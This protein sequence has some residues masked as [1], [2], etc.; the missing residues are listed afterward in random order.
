MVQKVLVISQEYPPKNGGAGVYG[1]N[2]I[3]LLNEQY[4]VE[5]IV[6]DY[7]LGE[8][9]FNTS[10][11]RPV[12]GIGFLQI[13]LHFYTNILLLRKKYDLIIL[14]DL[15]ASLFG[16]LLLYPHY[17]KKTISI[18]H[19]SEPEVIVDGERRLY[20][21]LH[22]RQRYLKFLE[23]IKCVW[24]VSKDLQNKMNE[25][26]G[27]GALKNTRIVPNFIDFDFIAGKSLP[28]ADDGIF[29]FISVGRV[30]KKKGFP[31]MF[32]IL[33]ALKENGYNFKWEI[34][35]TGEFLDEFKLQVQSSIISKDVVFHG[36]INQ[37]ELPSLLRSAHC[38]FLLS[39]YRESFGRVYVEAAAA[40][41][42]C[43]GN[44]LGGVSDAI[45]NNVNGILVSPYAP[46][47]EVLELLKSI[48]DKKHPFDVKRIIE[49]ARRYSKD[50]I[51]GVVFK[52]LE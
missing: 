15:G 50:S 19:G 43:I 4:E 10:F 23:A 3:S 1:K 47:L 21:L 16:A 17:Y 33:S 20:K 26:I 5:A 51:R 2:L 28:R 36:Y 48:L 35:G 7:G 18:I 49:S 30:V 14:N 37:E 13:A 41:C 24:F 27:Y 52:A 9:I 34:V 45:I 6:G 32:S 12:K 38:L 11:F 8:S 39:E 44:N 40:G 42:I 22:L 25:R 46:E 31:K 29:R